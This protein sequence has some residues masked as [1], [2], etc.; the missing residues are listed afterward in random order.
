[1]KHKSEDYKI[2]AAKYYL[3]SLNY[4]ETAII[5]GCSRQSLMRWVKQF[6]KNRNIKRKIKK[7]ISYKITKK[8]IFFI[9]HTLKRNKQITINR[10]HQKLIKNF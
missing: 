9:K 2:S 5:F 7:N 10:L 1:M 6:E 4:T 8:Y 3:N